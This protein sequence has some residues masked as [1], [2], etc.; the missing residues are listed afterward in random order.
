MTPGPASS[1]VHAR[2]PCKVN[3]F[4]AVG[5]LLDD[6]YHHV[7]IAY[8]GASLYEDVRASRADDFSVA[9]TGSVELSRVPTDGANIAIR[10]AR[11]LAAR[12]GYTGGAHLHIEK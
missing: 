7:A 4:L 1:V 3:V 8:Q 9:V 2:A 6:G 12:T 5:S 11:L 10:A